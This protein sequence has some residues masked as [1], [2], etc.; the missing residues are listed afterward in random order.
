MTTPTQASMAKATFRYGSPSSWTGIAPK[1]S[2]AYSAPLVTDHAL[3]METERMSQQANYWK[4][5][6]KKF[7]LVGEFYKATTAKQ[8]NVIASEAVKQSMSQAQIAKQSTVQAEYALMGANANT[9]TA[10]EQAGMAS[11]RA[12]ST[13]EQRKI[14][15]T[16]ILTELRSL[17]LTAGSNAV[18]YD[19]DKEITRLQDRVREVVRLPQTIP[20][21]QKPSIS[22]H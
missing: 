12:F 6:Q 19:R 15:Q 2:T 11:D 18:D 4:E 5:Q 8:K 10:A 9:A 3:A 14:Q 7:E 17:A 1:T 21:A 13:R 16:T 20:V 22:V